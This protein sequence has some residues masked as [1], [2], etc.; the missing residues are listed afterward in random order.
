[1]NTLPI[2]ASPMIAAPTIGQANEGL[3]DSELASADPIG[4][5]LD[6]YLSRPADDIPPTE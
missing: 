1:M 4:A 5:W 2:I 6:R 3:L